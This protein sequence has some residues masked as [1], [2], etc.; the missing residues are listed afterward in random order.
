MNIT[1]DLRMAGVR[2]G[3]IA[4][5]SSQRKN[6]VVLRRADKQAVPI[7]CVFIDVYKMDSFFFCSIV[8]F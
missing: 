4:N 5:R 2:T 6:L 7:L 3:Y 1:N 8:I